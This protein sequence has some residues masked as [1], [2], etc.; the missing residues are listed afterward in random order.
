[1]HRRTWPFKVGCCFIFSLCFSFIPISAEDLAPN[2]KLPLDPKNVYGQFDNGLKYI[3]RRNANPPGKVALYLEVRTGALN[4]TDQ[5]NGLA[6]FLE[7]MAFK[8]SAHFKPTTLLPLLTHLGMQFGADTNAHTNLWETMFKLTMPDTKPDTIDTALNIF[9]DYASALSL[10]PVQIDSERRVILEELRARKGAQQRIHKEA[11][12]QVFAGTRLAVH[13]VTGSEEQIKTFPQSEFL[14]YWNTWYRPEN[15][16]LVVVGDID[17]QTIVAQAK[18]KLG[19]FKARAAGGGRMKAGIKPFDSAGAFVLSDP[20]QASAEVDLLTVR[21]A[22]PP[23]TTVS[24]YR[25]QLIERLCRW[26]VNRRFNDLVIKGDAPFREASVDGG[27][28]L[29]EGYT[30]SASAE[31]SHRIGTKSSTP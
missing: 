12:Q 1:M 7:H 18:P 5:Q 21:P 8:G 2:R 26:I 15:I 6:H 23:V 14:G 9:S 19:E 31:A 13:D 28:L 24:Q 25:R 4:E 10:Y 20:E 29:H 11:N 22:R 16:T 27:D 3:V 30:F 17:P